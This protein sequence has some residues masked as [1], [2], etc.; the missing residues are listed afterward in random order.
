MAEA[1]IERPDVHELEVVLFGP[2]YGECILLHVGRGYWI[3]VDSCM[4]GRNEPVA[5]KYLN[6]LGLD[7]SEAIK[8]VIATHW[9]EDHI[10][11]MAAILQTCPNADFCCAGALTKNEFFSFLSIS[12][13]ESFTS[14]GLGAREFMRI[15][16]ILHERRQLPKY[17]VQNR[18]MLQFADCEIWSLSP[19][20]GAY[21]KF[22][23]MAAGLIVADSPRR[24]QNFRLTPNQVSVSLMVNIGGDQVL[25]GADLD[26]S[27]WKGILND[28]PHPTR[29]ASLYKVAHHGSASGDVPG[30]WTRLLKPDPHAVL[31]PWQRGDGML[32]SAEDVKRILK[33]TPN[34]WITQ[35]Q[36][37][38]PA[39]KRTRAS[40]VEKLVRRKDSRPR[41]LQPVFGYIRLR[42]NLINGGEW[43]VVT[44]GRAG[45]LTDYRP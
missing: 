25:L 39:R 23:R 40:A 32:P 28:Y 12:S 11:G 34:A 13:G 27:G 5:L 14:S 43:K 8:A 36:P 44:E 18:K 16:T 21:E 31:T 33:R 2:G 9:H 17:A 26:G 30:I 29:R 10:R 22:L 45:H 42:R 20:D 19:T 38:R 41:P 15:I 4:H 24:K 7:P 1:C 6:Q 37:T 35:I 3:V